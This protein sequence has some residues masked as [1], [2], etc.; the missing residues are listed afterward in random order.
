MTIGN[1]ISSPALDASARGS[2]LASAS[3]PGQRL[4]SAQD[5]FSSALNRARG[6][7]PESREAAARSAAE[8]LVAI[9]FVQPV[10]AQ[11]RETNN[12]AA[13]FGPTPA[14]KQFGSVQDARIA[15]DIVRGARFPLVDQ[16]ARSMLEHL[17]PG[18][19]AAPTSHGG[20]HDSDTAPSDAS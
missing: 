12:A 5:Q 10:L 1:A 2:L 14:E 6:K 4:A 11:L 17:N 7:T 13:P 3:D 18:A 8:E 19:S 20:R 15:Q 16:L 9:T